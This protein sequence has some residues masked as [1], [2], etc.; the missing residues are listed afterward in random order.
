MYY[1]I[2][3]KDWRGKENSITVESKDVVK[4]VAILLNSLK[5]STFSV[6]FTD[7]KVPYGT[8]TTT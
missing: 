2:D 7:Q 5:P 6:T 1:R 8:V 4:F 3:W